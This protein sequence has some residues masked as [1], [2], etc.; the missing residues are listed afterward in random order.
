LSDILLTP[1]LDIPP[2]IANALYAVHEVAVEENTELLEML[3]SSEEVPLEPDST[4]L[5]L[6]A[7]PVDDCA[8]GVQVD[9]PAPVL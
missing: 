2:E 3:A 9:S 8:E 5:E 4:L 1:E 6:A 7:Q